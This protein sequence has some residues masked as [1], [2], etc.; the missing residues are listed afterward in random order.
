MFD[1]LKINY[2]QFAYEWNT[3]RIGVSSIPRMPTHQ[4]EIPNLHKLIGISQFSNN[5]TIEQ[6]NH[7][8]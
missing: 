4:Q 1:M 3:L 2:F 8:S 5:Q 6:S 7:K